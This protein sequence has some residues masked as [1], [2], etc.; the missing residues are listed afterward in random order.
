MTAAWTLI[1][2]F[3]GGVLLGSIPMAWILVRWHTRRHLHDAGSGNVGA[4]NAMRVSGSR[5]VGVLAMV[6]DGLKGATAVWAAL[7]LGGG[8][9]VDPIL[10][11]GAGAAGAVAGH[12]YNPWLSLAAGRLS[13][14]KGFAAAAGALFAFLP[15]LVVVWLGVGLLAWLLLKALRGIRDE[16]PASTLATLTIP[17]AAF[18][19]YGWQAA[20]VGAAVALVILPRLLREA[21][22][23]LGRSAAEDPTA[24]SS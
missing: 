2:A 13:G 22:R 17:V 16:A 15:W 5:W 23:V 18:W 21:A 4:L 9:G 3:F 7:W 19:I 11:Q 8:T 6:L 1:G 24:A 12:N 20:W 10:L 14:G